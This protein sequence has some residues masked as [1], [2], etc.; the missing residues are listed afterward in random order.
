[1]DHKWNVRGCKWNANGTQMERKW[2]INGCK[3]DANGDKHGSKWMQMERASP[4]KT[5]YDR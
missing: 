1:M 4:K 2:N 5:L 3:I